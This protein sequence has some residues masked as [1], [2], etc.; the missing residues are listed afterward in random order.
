MR[1]TKEQAAYADWRG[2]SFL[3][4]GAFS[5]V[6]FPLVVAY[7]RPWPAQRVRLYLRCRPIHGPPGSRSASRACTRLELKA[8]HAGHAMSEVHPLALLATHPPRLVS[9]KGLVL[10]H[11]TVGV[12]ESL[13]DVSSNGLSILCIRSLQTQILESPYLCSFAVVASLR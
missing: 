9:S 6:C 2:V 5:R 7:Q 8:S 4:E 12:R 11:S 1:G 3:L 13:S 10:D